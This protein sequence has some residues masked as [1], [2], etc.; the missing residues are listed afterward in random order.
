MERESIEI[1]KVLDLINNI[2]KYQNIYLYLKKIYI[3]NLTW[4]KYVLICRVKEKEI[5]VVLKM[6][7]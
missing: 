2:E 3:K 4:K 5:N 7:L 1:L 6:H